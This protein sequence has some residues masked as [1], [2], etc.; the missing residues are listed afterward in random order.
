[1][2]D[3]F[4]GFLSRIPPGDYIFPYAKN[5]EKYKHLYFIKVNILKKN[6]S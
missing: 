2:V 4:T 1:V 3:E 5:T 6:E